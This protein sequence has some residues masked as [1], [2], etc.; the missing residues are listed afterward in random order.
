MFIQTRL[1]DTVTKNRHSAGD[2][3]AD[4][5]FKW[6]LLFIVAVSVREANANGKGALVILVFIRIVL[7]KINFSGCFPTYP[8]VIV[9]IT[10]F[11]L[12]PIRL[13]TVTARC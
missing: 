10:V 7:L 12:W 2:F 1:C 13:E 5:Y 8:H 3:A 4:V 9:F 6:W 11:G